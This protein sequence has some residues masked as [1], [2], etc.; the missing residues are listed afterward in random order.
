MQLSRKQ[1]SFSR[2]FSSFFKSSLNFDNF[3]KKGDPHDRFIS[4][5]TDS[6]KCD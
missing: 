6:T 2:F 1:K 5:I 3:E 4:E